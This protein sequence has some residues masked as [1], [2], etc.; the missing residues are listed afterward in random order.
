MLGIIF[1]VTLRAAVL[2]NSVI[3]VI[4]PSISEIFVL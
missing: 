1:S 4:L 3:L 2:T